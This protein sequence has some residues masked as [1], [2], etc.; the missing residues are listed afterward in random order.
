MLIR[1]PVL[2][3]MNR[4]VVAQREVAATP[5]VEHLDV[6]EQIGPPFTKTLNV[7]FRDSWP[8]GLGRKRTFVYLGSNDFPH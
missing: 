6:V 5:V 4:R 3:E 2:Q 1:D 8:T 7:R